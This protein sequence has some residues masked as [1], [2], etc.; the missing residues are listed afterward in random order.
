LNPQPE[1]R[2]RGLLSAGEKLGGFSFE[3]SELDVTATLNE[4]RDA[5][6]RL[7]KVHIGRQQVSEVSSGTP[8]S[9]NIK[10]VY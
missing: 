9:I 2:G 8:L 10:K 7:E 5:G 3:C 4:L 6:W 1:S